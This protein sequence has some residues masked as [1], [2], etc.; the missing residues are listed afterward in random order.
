MMRTCRRSKWQTCTAN[1][2]VLDSKH[3]S[4]TCAVH[5]SNRSQ[6]NPNSLS[7]DSADSP[8]GGESAMASTEARQSRSGPIR[9]SRIVPIPVRRSETSFGRFIRC[10]WETKTWD[11]INR[12]YSWLVYP[13]IGI[14]NPLHMAGWNII[15]SLHY[16]CCKGLVGS[17]RNWPLA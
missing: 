10:M 6:W 2:C 17:S 5:N 1:V 13:P 8:W 7:C 4:K 16:W 3:T 15:K 12:V 11:L 9:V 14:G